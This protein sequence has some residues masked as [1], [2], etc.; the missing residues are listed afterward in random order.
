MIIVAFRVV[1]YVALSKGRKL[2]IARRIRKIQR[3]QHA[4]QKEQDATESA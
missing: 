2:Y 1:L 3:G 4:D